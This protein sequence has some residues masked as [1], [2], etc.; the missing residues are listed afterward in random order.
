MFYI[1]KTKKAKKKRKEKKKILFTFWL[2]QGLEMK[3]SMQV[4]SFIVIYIAA[5]Y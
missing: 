5:Y 3:G 2:P 4:Q 1:F